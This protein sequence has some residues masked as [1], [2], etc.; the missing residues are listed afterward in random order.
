MVDY[1][2][3]ELPL[4][5]FVSVFGDG[6]SAFNKRRKRLSLMGKYDGITSGEET[7]G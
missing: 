2:D 4:P 7:T 3:D 1:M 5:S 6:Y